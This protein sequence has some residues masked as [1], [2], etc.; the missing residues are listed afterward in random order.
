MFK[1]QIITT[2][3]YA[4]IHTMPKINQNMYYHPKNKWTVIWDSITYREHEGE[5]E[6]LVSF[7]KS[8]AR[9]TKNG[10]EVKKK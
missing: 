4:S 6:G 7:K 8:V 1:D 2:D 5:G 10:K 3:G 9:K